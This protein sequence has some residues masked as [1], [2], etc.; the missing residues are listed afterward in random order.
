MVFI[1]LKLFLTI[2]AIPTILFIYLYPRQQFDVSGKHI[3]ITGGSSGIGL[4]LAKLYLRRGC[5]VTLVGRNKSKLQAAKTSLAEYKKYPYQKI[6]AL[7]VDVSHS[8]EEVIKEFSSA[9]KVLG[10]VQVLVNCAGISIAGDFGSLPSKE[11]ENMLK[12]NR[13][14]DLLH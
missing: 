9:V 6:L 10:P 2:L 7:S 4:A 14:R 5:H 11:F 12:V 3:L 13:P 1:S 8:E